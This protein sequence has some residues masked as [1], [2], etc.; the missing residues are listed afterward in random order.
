MSG[1]VQFGGVV[2]DE[3]GGG[4]PLHLSARQAEVDGS[5]RGV[6]DFG[7]VAEAVDGAEGIPGEMLGQRPLGSPREL[8]GG[9]DEG[10]TTGV[11]LSSFPELPV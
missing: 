5:H 11:S 1:E 3:D 7:P 6:S 2:N 8:R 4:D 9:L 10:V